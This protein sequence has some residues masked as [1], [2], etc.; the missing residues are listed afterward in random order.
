MGGSTQQTQTTH[1]TTQPWQPTQ[2]VLQNIVG[3][4]GQQTGNTGP[5][6]NQTSAFQT[7]TA[8][9][10][11]GNPYAGQIGMLA[12]TLLSG[13][14]D[15]TGM[16]NDAW[17]QYQAN[18][19]PFASGQYVDPSQNPALQGYLNTAAN[20]AT[21]RVNSYFAGAGRDL[22]GKNA[23]ALGRGISAATAP[24]LYDAYNQERARQLGA[25]GNLF[26]GGLGAAGALSGL[27]QTALGNQ[28]AG[29]GA[30]T[31][32]LQANDSAANQ[33][34]AVE[35]MQ[36]QLPWQ[37]LGMLSNLITPIAS[38]GGQTNSTTTGTTQQP[39]ANQIL[40]GAIGG[41]GLLGQMGAF[42]PGGWLLS[43]GAASGGAG[44]LSSML[45]MLLMS[46]R[47]IKTDIAQ[48]GALFDG[49]PVYRFRYKDDPVMRIGLMAQDV[50]QVAPH[51]VRD[52]NGVKMVDYA[53]ATEGA[54]RHDA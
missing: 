37:N 18:L 47:R 28:Q 23:E 22:S 46:D 3:Q 16:V 39:L 36:Q 43:G 19:S 35:A 12:N 34:L 14:P 2:P 33:L 13:G 5:T 7:L 40:G 27:D 11:N 42:G 52:M 31:A 1:S 30:S 9:A 17:S 48:V 6:Q 49:Q 53:A 24:I 45:P 8:N 32:A 38:L 4:I 26:T 15:R 54:L 44:A 51:A 50:E 25:I 29:I 20:D 10:Q 21:N 41:A